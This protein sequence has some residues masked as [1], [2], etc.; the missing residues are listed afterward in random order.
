MSHRQNQAFVDKLVREGGVLADR[1]DQVAA[2]LDF[3]EESSPQQPFI[4]FGSKAPVPTLKAFKDFFSAQ[5]RI[6]VAARLDALT[7]EKAEKKNLSYSE[8]FLEVMQE[9]M[10]LTLEYENSLP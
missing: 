2:I 9:N 4:E 8:A 7:K 10:D 1:R 5:P 6:N 3:V